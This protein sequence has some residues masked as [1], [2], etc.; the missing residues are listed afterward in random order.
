MVLIWPSCCSSKG[1]EVHGIIRRAS[2]FNT[3]TAGAVLCGPA[4]GQKPVASALWRPERRQRAGAADRQSPAGGNLQPGRAEPCAGQFRQPGIHG[5]YHGDGDGAP[6]GGH[7]RDGHSQPR[8]Y[9][10]SSS[11]MFGKVRETP[12]TERRLSIRAAL[13]PGQGVCVLDHG[14][15]PRV[16]RH[17]REQRDSVQPRVA[18][19]RGDLR[20]AEDHAGGGAH[21]GG[22]AGQAV[23]WGT[24]T[25]SGTG[26]TR[27]ST[28]RRCG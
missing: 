6:A 10:A 22:L 14:Q 5:G 8:F 23:S 24:W 7:A 18:A 11:E 13:T 25:P 21:Q 19:A 26:A 4:L 16:L 27:R 9:Q 15:L 28:W 2:T 17:A 3:G 20:D 1:Y 12:Q